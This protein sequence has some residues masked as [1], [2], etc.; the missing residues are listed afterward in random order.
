MISQLLKI[1]NE[2]IKGCSEAASDEDPRSSD[3][4]QS[5]FTSIKT[6]I[7]YCINISAIDVLF[8]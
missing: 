4:I 6:A 8:N 3:I 7:E 1:L 2:I 5:D